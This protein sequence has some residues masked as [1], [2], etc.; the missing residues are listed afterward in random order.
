MVR[1]GSAVY[2]L[3]GLELKALMVHVGLGPDMGLCFKSEVGPEYASS[4]HDLGHE[5][6]YR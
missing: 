4:W 6:P 3:A 5:H 2:G 1:L